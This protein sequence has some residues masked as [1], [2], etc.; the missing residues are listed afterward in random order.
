MVLSMHVRL[1]RII[2]SLRRVGMQAMRMGVYGLLPVGSHPG[3]YGSLASL[4]DLCGVA[5][6]RRSSYPGTPQV[7]EFGIEILHFT[8]V[9]WLND[10]TIGS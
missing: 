1:I 10:I 7:V 9:I 4:R 2:I 5:I 8:I 3:R 6:V